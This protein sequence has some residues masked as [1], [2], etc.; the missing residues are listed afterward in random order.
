MTTK[1]STFEDEELLKAI[2]S[3]EA[4][5]YAGKC[6]D[7]LDCLK[8]MSAEDVSKAVKEYFGVI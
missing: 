4:C 3:C 5:K 1:I 2:L 6:E 8:F 7:K